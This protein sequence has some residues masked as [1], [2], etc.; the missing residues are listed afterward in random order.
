MEKMEKNVVKVGISGYNMYGSGKE[1]V[2]RKQR[3][4]H[5]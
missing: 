4:Y 5:R 2:L 3:T 1:Y